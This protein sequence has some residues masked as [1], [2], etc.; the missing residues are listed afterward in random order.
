MTEASELVA[1]DAEVGLRSHRLL[2]MCLLIGAPPKTLR[3]MVQDLHKGVSEAIDVIPEVLSIHAPPFIGPQT[4][5]HTHCQSPSRKPE[6]ITGPTFPSGQLFGNMELFKEHLSVPRGIELCGLPELCFPDGFKIQMEEQ[7]ESFHFLVLTDLLGNRQQGVVLHIHREIKESDLYQAPPEGSEL[8]KHPAESLRVFVPYGICVITKFPYYTVLK[9]CLSCLLLDIKACG[10]REFEMKVK[11]FAAQLALVPCP[12]PGSLQ[13]CFEL[14]PLSIVLSPPE[15]ID[16]PVIDI[17]LHVP[18]LC[19]K[20]ETILQI[21]TYILIERRLVFFSS[22]WPLLTLVTE[23]FVHYLHPL[24]WRHPYIPVLANQMLDLVMAPTVFLMGCHSRHFETINEVEELVLVDVDNGTVLTTQHKGLE[25][26]H[27]PTAAVEE[28]LTS[29]QQLRANTELASAH[30]ASHTNLAVAREKKRCQRQ[31]M[32]RRVRQIFLQLIGNLLRDVSKHLNLKHRV[33]IKKE[34]LD[35]R[36]PASQPFYNSFLKTDLFHCFL[37]SRLNKKVDAFTRWERTDSNRVSWDHTMSSHSSATL[38]SDTLRKRKDQTLQSRQMLSTNDETGSPNSIT[39]RNSFKLTRTPGRIVKAPLRT[40]HLPSFPC[41]PLDS[42]SVSLYYTKLIVQISRAIDQTGTDDSEALAVCF[43]LRGIVRLAQGQSLQA[44]LDF[45][46]LEKINMNFFPWDLVK[47]TLESMSP[48]QL[49]N[50]Q[51]TEELKGLFYGIMEKHWDTVRQ[52]ESVK[53]YELPKMPLNKQDFG[54]HIQAAGI[55]SNPNSTDRLFDILTGGQQ[56]F[57]EPKM[58]NELYSHW[59]K[60]KSE[61]DSITLAPEVMKNLLENERISKVSNP[62]KT[63]Y[64]LGRVV[65]SQKRLFLLMEAH[66]YCKEIARFRDIE[67]VESCL[68]VSVFPL[69]IL[70]LRIKVRDKKEP[71]IANLKSERDLWKVIIREM[72]A[73]KFLAERHKDP[74]YIQQAINNIQLINAVAKC[75]L[76]QRPMSIASKLAYLDQTAG[77]EPPTVPKMTSDALKH[78]LHLSDS[79]STSY[80]VDVLLYVPGN[81]DPCESADTH[82]KLWCT[83]S[84]GRVMMYNAATWIMEQP[85]IQAGR[86]KL[87]C[88][89]GIGHEQVWLGSED[90]FIYII[91]ALNMTCNKRLVGHRNQVS[92]MIQEEKEGRTSQIYSC[93]L[94]GSIVLWDPEVMEMKSQFQLPQCWRLTSISLHHDL[95]WCCVEYSLLVLARD[96]TQMHEITITPSPDSGSILMTYFLII[97]QR[98]ELWMVCSQRANIYIWKTDNLTDPIKIIPLPGCT[99]IV[100]ML[101]VKKQIWLGG[102]VTTD[103]TKGRIYIVNSERYSLEKELEAPCGAIGALCSAEDRYVLSGTQDS[104]VVIWKVD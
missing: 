84:D 33:F 57:I 19:F 55:V 38:S 97:P 94:D 31:Q 14:G 82:P 3:D 101:H 40:L 27:L 35:S 87:N 5:L 79:N 60:I 24:Q 58:F 45:Q 95:L 17:G 6:E 93:S 52:E 83:L 99:E 61:V 18:F 22:N 96:G 67:E 54:I 78:T 41:D 28:F 9:D 21:L 7:D 44:L 81:L 68:P 39:S 50:V 34:F 86:S 69:K 77:E 42:L 56:K 26:P 100:C 75:R 70:A 16:S 62:V 30:L 72:C 76:H 47:H 1:G 74:Q 4:N 51:E 48:E 43:Y 25:T 59:N 2:E 53:N 88:M 71:F 66:P 63:S 91:D 64:G 37:K 36:Q 10:E 15:D 98:D 92:D 23:C 13:L 29:T 103:Q 65:M 102:G 46:N 20:P 8:A 32:N 12:P 49:Q 89:I 11:E 80:A 90:S 104:K 73:G 85:P